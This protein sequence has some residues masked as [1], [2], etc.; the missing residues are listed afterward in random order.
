MS[1]ATT[2]KD[3]AAACFYVIPR[4]GS[5]IEGPSIRLAEIALN[6]WGNSVA[7]AFITH[8]DDNYVYAL[9]MCR[10]LEK[11]VAFRFPSR[12]RIVDRNG[13]DITLI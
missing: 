4:A 8:E 3:I 7:Q 6:A 5:F 1:L 2:D 12:R 11:N 13:K 10:D 9:G